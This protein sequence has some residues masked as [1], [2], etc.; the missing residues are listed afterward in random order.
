MQCLSRCTS[1]YICV[2]ET[3]V[4]QVRPLRLGLAAELASSSGAADNCCVMMHWATT[5]CAR[6][7]TA[8]QPPFSHQ[9]ATSTSHHSSRSAFHLHRQ[10]NKASGS[11]CKMPSVHLQHVR[12]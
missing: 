12:H 5:H 3:T 7:L 10:H 2:I 4:Q 8:A 6:L 1:V 9:P 11:K